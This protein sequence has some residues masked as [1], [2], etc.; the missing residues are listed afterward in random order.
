MRSPWRVHI[1][2]ITVLVAMALFAGFLWWL[3]STL[4]AVR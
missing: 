2:A 3:L 1:D 4:N